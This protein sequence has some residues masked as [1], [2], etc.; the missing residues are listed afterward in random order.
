LRV[1]ATATPMLIPRTR[2]EAM[3]MIKAALRSVLGRIERAMPVGY[4]KVRDTVKAR[5]LSQAFTGNY[6]DRGIT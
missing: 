4:S 5:R 6:I 2:A 3:V 1:V